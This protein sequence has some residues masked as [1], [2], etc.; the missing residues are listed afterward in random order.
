VAKFNVLSHRLHGGLRKTTKTLSQNSR[1][2]GPRFEWGTS[3]IRNRG[4]NHLTM[5]FVA[6][7]CH[8][9]TRVLE[10]TEMSDRQECDF[11]RQHY[12]LQKGKYDIK[13][14]MRLD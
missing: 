13:S 9:H 11:I 6:C 1:S 5:T 14:I 2:R 8:I 3:L 4:V 12:F 7:G 10:E